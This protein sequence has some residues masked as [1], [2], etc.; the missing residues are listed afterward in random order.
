MTPKKGQNVLRYEKS[1]VEKLDEQELQFYWATK[2]DAEHHNLYHN[3]FDLIWQ[4]AFEALGKAL[5]HT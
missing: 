2:Q 3:T 1:L 4:I 5:Y